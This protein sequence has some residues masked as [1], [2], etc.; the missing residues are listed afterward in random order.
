LVPGE[1]NALLHLSELD[2]WIG[3]LDRAVVRA[4]CSPDDAVAAYDVECC[5][6]TLTENLSPLSLPARVLAAFYR[7]VESSVRLDLSQPESVLALRTALLDL[8][9]VMAVLPWEE[10]KLPTSL[11]VNCPF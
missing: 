6:E 11:D 8:V 5:I 10:F 3:R 4:Q 7:A 2:N 9:A 1:E